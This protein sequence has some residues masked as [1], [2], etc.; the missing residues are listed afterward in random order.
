MKNLT[1]E[2][3]NLCDKIATRAIDLGIYPKERR[4]TAFM[5]MNN[6]AKNFDMD[7]DGLLNADEFDFLHDIIGIGNAINRCKGDF[8]NDPLFVPRYAKEAE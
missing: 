3:I 5:D 4:I 7:L 8:S 2:Q 6:M 1:K